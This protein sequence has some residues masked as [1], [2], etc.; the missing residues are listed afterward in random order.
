V[1]REFGNQTF[2][3][4][5]CLFMQ[6]MRKGKLDGACARLQETKVQRA[7]QGFRHHSVDS[8]YLYLRAEMMMC[9]FRLAP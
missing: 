9:R 2:S 4:K 6:K 5:H 1:A 8:K 3:K 7:L